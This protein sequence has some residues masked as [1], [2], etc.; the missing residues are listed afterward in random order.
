MSFEVGTIEVKDNEP[1]ILVSLDEDGR[2]VW[3]NLYLFWSRKL[4]VQCPTCA[5]VH[6]LR[7]VLRKEFQDE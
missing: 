3:Q 7:N 4:H 1:K 6:P 2:E 5:S